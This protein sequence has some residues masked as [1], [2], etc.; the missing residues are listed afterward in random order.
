M[1]KGR[2]RVR[3]GGDVFPY[4]FSF[5][6]ETTNYLNVWVEIQVRWWSQAHFKVFPSCHSERLAIC[7]PVLLPIHLVLW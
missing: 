2:N 6:I 3:A 5:H 1:K 7:R 4:S